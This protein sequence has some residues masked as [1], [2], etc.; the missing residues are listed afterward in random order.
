M[1]QEVCRHAEAENAGRPQSQSK[2]ADGVD[3]IR[4]QEPRQQ[5]HQQ[6]L[7]VNQHGTEASTSTGKSK[8]EQSLE[9]AAE[10]CGYDAKKCACQPRRASA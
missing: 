9:Q 3:G 10:S 8:G 4:K 2:P 5:R 6:G 7:R 1:P